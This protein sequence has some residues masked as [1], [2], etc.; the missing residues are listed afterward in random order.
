[1][2]KLSEVLTGLAAFLDSEGVG[3][4][5]G[6]GTPYSPGETAVTLK[7]LPTSPDAAIAIASYDVEDGTDQPVH[8]VLVQLRFRAGGSRTAVDDLAD[9]AKTVLHMRHRYDLPGG[10]RVQRSR[11]LSVADLG[12]DDNRREERADNYELILHGI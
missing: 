8:R 4:W 1:M 10:V 7:R 6:D 11:R 3:T 9:A 2:T 5:R 12:T